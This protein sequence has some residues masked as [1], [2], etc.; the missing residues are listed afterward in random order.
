[1][2]AD[3]EPI[4]VEGKASVTDFPS[5]I[6]DMISNVQY[7]LFFMMLIVFIIVSSDMFINRALAKFEGA[8]DGRCPTSWGTVLQGSFLVLMTAIMDVAIRYDII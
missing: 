2:P 4:K 5:M 6:A 7:K 8:V 3:S 1:M